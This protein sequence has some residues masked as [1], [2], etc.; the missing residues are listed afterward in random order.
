MSLDAGH[1]LLDVPATVLWALG[2]ARPSWY[3]GTPITAPFAAHHV[4]AARHL[5]YVPPVLAV[6]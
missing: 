6:A 4:H 1:T 3:A 2:V 5:P